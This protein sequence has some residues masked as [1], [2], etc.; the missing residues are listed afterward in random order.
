MVVIAL[1]RHENLLWY[2]RAVSN[3]VSKLYRYFANIS[4]NSMTIN[5]NTRLNV[6]QKNPKNFSL[7]FINAKIA[8]IYVSFCSLRQPCC[9]CSR[10]MLIIL[11]HLRLKYGTEKSS[12][13]GLSGPFPYPYPNQKRIETGKV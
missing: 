10:F 11:I 13:E 9:R 6:T 2:Y 5:M 12:F 1:I 8:Y 3:D 7:I 4:L